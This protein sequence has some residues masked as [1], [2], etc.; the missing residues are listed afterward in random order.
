MIRTTKRTQGSMGKSFVFIVLFALT[1]LAKKCATAVD[2]EEGFFVTY[3]DSST[4]DLQIKSI[5]ADG[6]SD[7]EQD[8]AKASSSSSSS[9]SLRGGSIDARQKDNIDEGLELPPIPPFHPVHT[10]QVHYSSVMDADGTVTYR[11]DIEAPCDYGM[12]VFNIGPASDDLPYLYDVYA[13]AYLWSDNGSLCVLY[14][15]Y[16]GYQVSTNGPF[17]RPGYDPTTIR[18]GD[19]VA[20]ARHMHRI[21]SRILRPATGA[22]EHS[23]S[24]NK[25]KAG[26]YIIM[27]R[28]N[29]YKINF[30]KNLK[31]YVN[32]WGPDG[33]ND[34]DTNEFGWMVFDATASD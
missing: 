9:S 26:D 33:P 32:G 31:N 29:F 17:W 7:L 22:T 20:D 3:S 12:L 15:T 10:G 21:S 16:T 34:S 25:T 14:P 18:F 2:L 23:N 19:L 11:R 30:Y 5:A 13:D 24:I 27:G 1:A 28:Y 8:V 6:V 4:T